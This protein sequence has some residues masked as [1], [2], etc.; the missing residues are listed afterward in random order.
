MI[1]IKELKLYLLVLE[2]KERIFLQFFSGV[3]KE[4]TPITFGYPYL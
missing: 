2:M 3:K 1:R 4:K